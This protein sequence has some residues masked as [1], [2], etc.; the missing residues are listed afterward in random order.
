[1]SSDNWEG[2]RDLDEYKGQDWKGSV[3]GGKY[4][5]DEKY[6]GVGDYGG[7]SNSN[8][9]GGGYS[10]GN[11]PSHGK[12]NGAIIL[13][14]IGLVVGGALF[15]TD[16]DISSVTQEI[17]E[18]VNDIDI[19][20]VTQEI[21]EKVNDIDISSVTQEINEKVWTSGDSL[22]STFDSLDSNY[23]T[24]SH[25]PIPSYA[26]EYDVKNSISNA[27]RQ[28]M[29]VNPD[30]VIQLVKSGGEVH[31]EWKKNILGNH[32]GQITGGMMEVELG[33]NDCMGNWNQ[34]AVFSLSD[35]IS[36]E[37]GHYVGLGHSSD[38]SHLMWGMVEPYP[39]V[40]FD[41]LEYNIPIK[42]SKFQSWIEYDILENE[43]DDLN[44]DYIKLD[45]E[46]S[47][48][49]EIISSESQYQKAMQLYNQLNQLTT[50]MNILVDE[51]N[52]IVDVT[53]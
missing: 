19:S 2:D 42:K 37:I 46:Y 8:N 6:R 32:A 36:H 43:Y 52:C 4:G 31:I 28:W 3:F 30:M 9:Y 17:N 50:E 11:T 5:H 38:E 15:V 1:M 7:S 49:P 44:R 39:D 12:R 51:M 22:I 24:I 25:D 41:D 33:S 23:I 34:Y 16:I 48:Y 45:R 13:L 20:S 53:P 35:T 47:Q 29:N 27:L 26:N 21:N 40:N 10:G 14:V 18:K